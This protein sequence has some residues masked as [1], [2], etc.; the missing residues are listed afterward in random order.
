MV[1]VFRRIILY[2]V[3]E[4]TVSIGCEISKGMRG[5]GS[6]KVSIDLYMLS[7]GRPRDGLSAGLRSDGTNLGEIQ[8]ECVRMSVGILRRTMLC[9]WLRDFPP[10]SALMTPVLSELMLK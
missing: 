4:G 1:H 6:R 9:S 8:I 3:S 7:T 10:L 5:S 2:Y